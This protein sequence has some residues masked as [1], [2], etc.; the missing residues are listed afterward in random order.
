MIKIHCP[1]G[2][3]VVDLFVLGEAE[4]LGLRFELTSVAEDE[5]RT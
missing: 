2:R 4:R 1:T 5:R 3:H